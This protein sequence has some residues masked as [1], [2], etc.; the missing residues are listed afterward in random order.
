MKVKWPPKNRER[1]LPVD[2]ESLGKMLVQGTYRQIA[3]AAWK[4]TSI[5]KHLRELMVRE[6]KQEAC[7]RNM[8]Q[9]H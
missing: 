8:P 4:N 7:L 3:N 6:L 2:L 9:E 1:K 5:N